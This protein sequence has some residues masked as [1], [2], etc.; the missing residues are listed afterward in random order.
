ME[1]LYGLCGLLQNFHQPLAVCVLAHEFGGRLQFLPAQ[2]AIPVADG[3][4]TGDDEALP[5]LQHLHEG[6]CFA[7]GVMRAQIQPGESM[8]KLFEHESL[9]PQKMLVD[10]G[11]FKLSAF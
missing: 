8:A 10:A 7:E 6:G 1:A 11:D 9:F 4:Q 5:L 2:P 3:L